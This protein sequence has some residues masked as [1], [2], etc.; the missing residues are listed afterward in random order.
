ML[1][2]PRYQVVRAQGKLVF[3]VQG[4]MVDLAMN[5]QKNL[6]FLGQWVAERRS[7]QNKKL[8]WML[9]GFAH[10][11]VTLSDRAEF[12]NK[13]TK[14]S[15]P[16]HKRCI[17]GDDLELDIKWPIDDNHQVSGNNYASPPIFAKAEYFS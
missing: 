2:G 17:R 3:V 14:Y 13:T 1:R 7:A 12:L 15:A 16:Q 11:F 8:L 6:P 5:F 9:Q 10:G 4:E